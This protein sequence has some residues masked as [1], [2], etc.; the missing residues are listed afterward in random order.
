MRALRSTGVLGMDVYVP[1]DGLYGAYEPH[2]QPCVL[3]DGLHQ[4][5]GGGLALGARDAYRLQLFC[6]MAEPGRKSENWSKIEKNVSKY[7]I[8][9]G[10]MR[11]LNLLEGIS[12]ECLQG[13]RS[14]EEKP[15]FLRDGRTRPRRRRP[16]R[17][18]YLPL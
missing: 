7:W 14:M 4:V 6:G 12:W 13:K 16:W 18:W 11:L 9:E 15:T 10:T 5:G 3:Q 1:D 8:T 17:I 2:L